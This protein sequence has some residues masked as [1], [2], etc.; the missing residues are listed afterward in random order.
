MREKM[1][2]YNRISHLFLKNHAKLGNLL[3][4]IRT[5]SGNCTI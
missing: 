2:L 5:K 1:N 3:V 4:K